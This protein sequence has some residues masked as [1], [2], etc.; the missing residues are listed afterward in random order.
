MY[1]LNIHSAIKK[2]TISEL[3]DFIFENYCRRL[4]FTKESSYNLITH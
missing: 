2:M 1:I 3:K 4:G